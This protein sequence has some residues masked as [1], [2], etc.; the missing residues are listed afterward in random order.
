MPILAAYLLPHPPLVIPEIAK[1]KEKTISK[2]YETYE[3]IAHEIALLEPETIIFISPH[4]ESYTDYFQIAD[5][6]VGLGSFGA[7]KAHN[8]NFR[9]F[10]DRQLISSIISIVKKN[11]FPAGSEK[12]K[13]IYLDHGTMVPLYFINKFYRNFK[14][15]RLGVSG[16]SLSTHYR[17]G[18]MVNEAIDISNKKVVVIC[19][20]D[21]S[22][23]VNENSP[24]G[25]KEEGAIYD[26]Q[27]LKVLEKGNFGALL[28]WNK[29]NLSAAQE[30]AHRSITLM[31]GILDR[32]SVTS[33][34]CSYENLTGIGYAIMSFKVI[35]ENASRAFLELYRSKQ[36]FAV[37]VESDNA[38]DYARLA[39]LAIEKYVK[40]GQTPTLTN[41][42]PSVFLNS[43]NGVF[44]TLYKDGEIRGCMGSVKPL[45]KN[46]GTEIINSAIAS[47]SL[48]ARFPKVSSEELPF[49]S[50]AVD[51]ISSPIP[52]LSVSDLDPKKYGIV[53]EFGEKRA[54]LLPNLPSIETGEE[55]ILMAK[56]KAQ[57]KKGED[58]QLYRFSVSHHI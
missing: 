23:V 22:H 36:S 35:G 40:T 57:I 50:I 24:Y 15:V 14:A 12:G 30:C 3:N 4:A 39:R 34:L 10:Y 48:D 51:V 55:Q 25:F 1:G 58:V 19:S 31:A 56:K 52:I 7:Y 17:F 32:L 37:K 29:Q 38:D 21:L 8:V 5:A 28:S 13:E 18:Q 20:G 41:E 47:A 45:K 44:V 11:N 16:L 6:E 42:W 54:A 53:V 9:L 43:K 46:L 27:L 49:I 26:K 2:T 33:K